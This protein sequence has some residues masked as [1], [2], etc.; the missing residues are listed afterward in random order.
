MSFYVPRRFC[1]RRFGSVASTTTLSPVLGMVAWYKAESCSSVGDGNSI[2][3]WPDSSGNSNN[4]SVAT[5]PKYKAN[6]G[7][8]SNMG[9]VEFTSASSQYLTLP[10]GV[11]GV[12]QGA[13]KKAFSIF[14]VLKISGTSSGAIV[15]FADTAQTDRLATTYIAATTSYGSVLKRY[16]GSPVVVSGTTFAFTSWGVLATISYTQTGSVWANGT[17]E[18]NAGAMDVDAQ[19]T[20][21]S[22]AIGRAND[23]SPGDYFNGQIGEIIIYGSALSDSD[24]AINNT[25]LKSRWGTP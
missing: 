3:S 12:A 11:W 16:A 5:A 24:I 14:A 22:G 20:I 17:R 19:V 9:V 8:N 13:T 25:Y 10:F 6:Q 18:T 4:A 7:P 15:N 23:A 1:G 2:T 21:N